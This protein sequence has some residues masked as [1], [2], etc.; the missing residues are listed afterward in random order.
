MPGAPG[1]PCAQHIN[2]SSQAPE[3]P[4]MQLQPVVVQ[5][6]AQKAPEK[7][8]GGQTNQPQQSASPAQRL[9]S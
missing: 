7:S 3:V 4:A 5:A 8:P 6:L 9:P 1:S 2:P